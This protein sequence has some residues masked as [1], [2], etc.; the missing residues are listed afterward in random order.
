MSVNYTPSKNEY[1]NPG[2][3][4]FWCQKVLP[5]VYD[6]SLSYYETLNKIVVYL[7]KTIEDTARMGEDVTA[8]HEAYVKL[9]E[10]VNDYFDNLNVQSEI[11]DKLN[12]MAEDGSLTALVMPFFNEYKSELDA[13]HS[14]FKTEVNTTVG[15]QNERI[16][17]VERRMDTFTSLPNGSTS[18]DAELADI[19][20][21]GDGTNYPNAGD[22]VR[23]YV[24]KKYKYIT[25]GENLDD[26]KD[27]GHFI[28]AYGS[29]VNNAPNN[30]SG[31]RY[32]DVVGVA[33]NGLIWQT[34]YNANTKKLYMRHRHEGKFQPWGEITAPTAIADILTGSDLDSYTAIGDY[35]IGWSVEVANAPVADKG[36]RYLSVLSTGGL[37]WQTFYH[38]TKGKLYMRQRHEGKFNSW[39]EINKDIPVIANQ[40]A[41]TVLNSG[42]DLDTVVTPGCYWIGYGSA[43]VNAP[44]DASGMKYLTVVGEGGTYWQTFYNGNTG[45]LYMR[46]RHEGVYKQWRMINGDNMVAEDLPNGTDLDTVTTAGQY[47]IGWGYNIPNAPTSATGMRYLSVVVYL[48]SNLV[49]QTFYHA[50]KGELY[51]R[52][53]HEGKFQKW[54]KIFPVSGDNGVEDTK[55]IDF[56]RTSDTRK[57]NNTGTR[58]KVLSYN[59]ANYNNDT[60]TYINDAQLVAFKKMLYKCGADF[61]GVQEER[62]NLDGSEQNTHDHLYRPIYGYKSGDGGTTV[63][64]KKVYEKANI[65]TFSNGRSFRYCT[66]KINNRILAIGS[67]HAVAGYDGTAWDSVES[68]SARAV[69]YYELMSFVNHK[70]SLRQYG[71]TTELSMPEWDYCIIC[72]DFN[73]ATQADKNNIIQNATENG[74]HLANGGYLGWVSTT[75]T[76]V[77]IDNIL[78]SNNCVINNF[79]VLSSLG[80]ALY[81]DHLPV[82]ADIM[83]TPI[84]TQFKIGNGMDGGYHECETLDGMTWAEWCAEINCDGLFVVETID[85]VPK[86]RR[87]SDMF[88]CIIRYDDGDYRDVSPYEVIDPNRNYMY[89]P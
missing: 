11:D 14:A 81:S 30:D 28:L 61:I 3:F 80:A 4:R 19:R 29:T 53:K 54:F 16:D 41:T 21:G 31:I 6:D 73:S 8:L 42:V 75:P 66:Y 47:G 76:D 87:K 38:A 5:L 51:M 18:G 62:A 20:V 24:P 55:V 83:L 86:V 35:L 13:D 27:T 1:N 77:A 10:F 57:M 68:V 69:Q 49:W 64:S 60:S 71:G 59:V 56:T 36:M 37:V 22:A 85:S 89:T 50:T 26:Y 33:E 17:L 34:F 39:I 78:C 32:L 70:I 65:V 58:V 63:Y 2:A 7:N 23:S 72:G 43:M 82:V 88:T 9:Q 15:E 12:R 52:Q 44:S 40:F 67:F 84:M 25:A 46:H 79:E 45:E 74:F 48:N